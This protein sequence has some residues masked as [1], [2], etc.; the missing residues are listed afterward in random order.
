MARWDSYSIQIAFIII[1]VLKV[2][3]Y[4]HVYLSHNFR[5]ACKKAIPNTISYILLGKVYY[6][7][8]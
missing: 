8:L 6:Y 7:L 1:Y 2:L 5:I 4:H 3:V